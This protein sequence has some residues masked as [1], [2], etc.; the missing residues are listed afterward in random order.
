[1]DKNNSSIVILIDGDNVNFTYYKPLVE[2]FESH[3]ITVSEVNLFGKLASKYVQDWRSF[4][5]EGS[6]FVECPVAANRKN[7]TDIQIIN[8]V[9]QKYH[10]EHIK[11]FCLMSSDADFSYI[12]TTLPEDCMCAVAYCKERTAVS[13][14]DFLNEN[15]IPS[16]N[17][18]DLRG[19]ITEELRKEIV[20]T[21]LTSYLEYKLSPNFFD[22]A[23]VASWTKHRFGN[24]FALSA[25]DIQKMCESKVLE[26]TPE[27][28]KVKDLEE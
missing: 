20:N 25:D 10:S 19:P 9:Y 16:V 5:K 3:G 21:I 4:L 27:G 22:Y 2:F 15:N 17:L 12:L 6:K 1:M 28:V 8:M 23:T 14:I 24:S 13:Y 11:Y 18:E 7:S 26:F